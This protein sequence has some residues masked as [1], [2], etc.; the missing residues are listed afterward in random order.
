[1]GSLDD[2]RRSQ[3]TAGNVL[4]ISSSTEAE[5]WIG[6]MT[7]TSADAIDV[8]LIAFDSSAHPTLRH[9]YQ[10]P[11]QPEL[12]TAILELAS[13]GFNEIDRMGLLDRLLGQEIGRAIC[14]MLT[15]ANIETRSIRAIGSHGQTVRHRPRQRPLPFTLQIGCPATIAEITGITTVS[16]ASGTSP[17]VDKV[18]RWCHLPTMHCFIKKNSA[19]LWLILVALPI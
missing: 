16:F 7:G 11:L 3:I 10:H 13:P 6:V 17:L 2:E 19:L 8:A 12:R 1:M 15:E 4:T 18:L 5:L 14:D 9:F